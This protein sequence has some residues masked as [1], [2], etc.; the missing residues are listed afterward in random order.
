MLAAGQLGRER[1]RFS[2]FQAG[3]GVVDA[4]DHRARADLVGDSGDR[5]DL[6]AVDLRDH[7][8]RDVI[9]VL[10]CALNC[11]ESAETLAQSGETLLDVLLADLHGV[12]GNRE[13][14]RIRNGDLGAHLDGHGE[15]EILGGA[16][17]CG[18]G[19][20]IDLR[21]GHGV[22]RILFDSGAVI[23]VERA[24]DRLLDDDAASELGFNDA[25]GNVAAPE[26]GNVDLLADLLGCRIDG[27]FELLERHL[28]GQLDLGGIEI[29]DGALH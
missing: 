15:D 14:G 8:D 27:G 13:R 22:K 16:F 20:D 29:L 11:L 23:A 7:V 21:A 18:N 9:A 19:G 25:G 24:V 17:L 10:R 5:V 1:R 2:C 4:I 6:L 26:A 3:E 28:N 12:D